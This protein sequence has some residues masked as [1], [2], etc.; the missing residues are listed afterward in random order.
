MRGPRPQPGQID[1]ARTLR[2]SMTDAE[3]R[4]WYHLRNRRLAGFK[5][6]RQLPI[7]GYYADFACREA[8]LIIEADGGQHGSMRDQ[9]RDRALRAEGFAVLHFWNNDILGN[10]EGVLQTILNILQPN[11]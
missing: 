8:M 6:V 11:E 7:A 1:R 2:S 4:L 9:I 5:F 3:N 10:T